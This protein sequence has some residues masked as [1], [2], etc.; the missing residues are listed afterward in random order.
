MKHDIDYLIN[1]FDLIEFRADI[2]SDTLKQII[3]LTLNYLEKY[4]DLN[5]KSKY[6]FLQ[7]FSFNNYDDSVRMI[8]DLK[9]D[10]KKEFD[11]IKKVNELNEYHDKLLE[12]YNMLSDKE[13]HQ[14]FLDFTQNF[15][16]LEDYDS[17][18]LKIKLVETPSLL[19]KYAKDMKNCAGSYVNR[20]SQ[21]QYLFLIVFD[22]SEEK[23][24]E[25]LNEFMLGVF[26]SKLGL[27]FDQLK[28]S[29]NALA[30][31]RQKEMVMKFLEDKDIS[32][33]ELRD[34]KIIDE[35][36]DISLQGNPE[37]Y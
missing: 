9:W 37:M 11:K 13:K 32:Y 22:I 14:K 20:V 10:R 29:C 33:K 28:G 36:K 24:T 34:L 23:S 18:D 16:Y 26:V 31:N 17:E 4:K 25:K 15:K 19:I 1:L 35:S 5:N 27:E 3:H 12:H 21:G 6:K 30:S 7:N 8:I 2:N